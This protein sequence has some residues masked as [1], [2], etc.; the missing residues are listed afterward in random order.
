MMAT[1]ARGAVFLQ[2][3]LLLL[4]LLRAGAKPIQIDTATQ[5]YV[6]AE[7][8]TRIF[9]GVNAVF[10][11]PPW[12]PAQDGFDTT[13]TLSPL[14]AKNL[15]DVFGFT[16]MRLGFMWPGL[17]PSPPPGAF[18]SEYLGKVQK[19]VEF[20]GEA[21]IFTILD[22]HQDIF[23][24]KWC[25]EGAPDW[26]VCGLPSYTQPFAMP[27]AQ[28]I[29]G[30]TSDHDYPPLDKCLGHMFGRYYF[31][32]AVGKSFQALYD[33]VLCAGQTV[34][35]RDAFAKFWGHAASAFSKSN[36]VLGY[37]LINEPWA[38]D[39]VSHPSLL[40]PG[41]ADKKNLEPMYQQLHKAIRAADEDHIV[42]FEHSLADIAG[43]SGFKE[44]PGG[45]SYN[46]RQ[47]LSYHIYCAPGNS[48]G[49][50]RNLAECDAEDQFPFEMSL[51]DVKRFGC[52]GFMTE[53]G[54]MGQTSIV[55][56][57]LDF[58]LGLADSRLQSWTYWQYKYFKD[59]TTVR[60]PFFFFSSLSIYLLRFQ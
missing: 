27:A 9:H 21:G 25:G 18:S 37:E 42:F 17:A 34:G 36:Y 16:A 45:P 47:A 55:E 19:T 57:N 6:D 30:N 43:R 48:S 15:S 12:L 4:L 52:G 56:K 20:L 58:L 60:L 1:A 14:D 32:D 11:I 51:E 28:E 41:V 2:L 46:N 22:A 26:A 3:L 59:L 8:R 39:V 5:H 33:N 53:F 31:S 29:P 10:K 35:L 24:R 44:G 50:P 54:A 13:T 38:G 7:G 40:L 23:N 49:N